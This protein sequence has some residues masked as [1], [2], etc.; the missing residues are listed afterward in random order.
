L[1]LTLPTEA[2]WEFAA[3]AGT[4]TPWYTGAERNSLE[5]KVNIA[6]QAG[7]RVGA[8]W[9][10][11]ADWPELDDGY[12]VHAP[13]GSYPPNPFGLHEVLGNV[14]EWCADL[15]GKYDLEVLPGTGERLGSKERTRVIRG[16]GY[17]NAAP[18][19][20]SAYRHWADPVFQEDDVGLRPARVLSR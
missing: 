3:R 5:R 20:R 15:H 9:P 13:A 11:L 4:T 12:A 8:T 10:D 1:S 6:D 17:G 16:G 19:A 2:Q 18:R 14:W 7:A